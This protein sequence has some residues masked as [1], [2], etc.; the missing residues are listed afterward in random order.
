MYTITVQCADGGDSATNTGTLTIGPKHITGSFTANNKVYD[1]N[2]SA[3]VATRSL[4]GVISPDVVTL[5]GGTATFS[6]KN[7]GNGKTVTLTGATLSGADAA[8]YV[9]DSVSTTTANITAKSLTGSFTA[10]DKQYDGNNSATV[11]TRSLRGRVIAPDVVTLTGGTATFSDKNVGNGKTVTLTGATLSGADAGNYVLGSV[12][13][14]TANIT[15]ADATVVVTPYTV[16]YDGQSHTATVTSITGVNGETGATVGTVDVSGTTHVMANTY[17]DTWSFTGTANYNN[18]AATSITD[19]INKKAVTWTTNPNSKTYGNADPSP[20]T[21]GS[22]TG[23]V[24]GD[25]VTASYTRV[26]GENAS[27]PTY[28]ISATLSATPLAALNNYTITNAGAEF[29]I[30]KHCHVDDQS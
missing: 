1:G 10:Q 13:T 19:T 11:L 14:T 27:R 21:T 23:F 12:S 6:N 18:I 5:T 16:T 4:S 22:G 7:V 25:A 20:L 30:D 9:L 8:K 17:N 3:T 15:K 24:A 29:T 28:H 26:A 2:N